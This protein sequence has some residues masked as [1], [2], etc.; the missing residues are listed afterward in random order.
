MSAFSADWLTLRESADKRARNSELAKAVAAWFSLR[1]SIKVVDLGC[2]TGANLR[3]TSPLLPNKQNWRL[4][5]NDGQL[6]AAARIALRGWADRS[7]EIPGGLQLFKGHAVISVHFEQ[8]DIAINPGEIIS[9]TE[10]FAP[11]LVTASAFFDLVSPEFIKTLVHAV[12][13]QRAVF[14]TVLTYNGL[15]A[16]TPHRP[17]DNQMAAAFNRHQMR[18]KGFGVAA[19][20]AAPSHMADQFRLEG[21]SVQE[22]ESPWLLGRNDRMLISELLQGHAHAVLE[23]KSV[24]AKTVETWIK[25]TRTAAQIGHTDTF[26]VPG[27]VTE[28]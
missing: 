22:G 26:A 18:D 11:D 24:D 16:W 15:Q 19:G 3:A 12:A 9:G 27:Q 1:E 8:R 5:D 28:F 21:Y 2:G 23:T 14:Y 4:I 10:H 7:E 6:L 25:V 20:P 13:K 17:A